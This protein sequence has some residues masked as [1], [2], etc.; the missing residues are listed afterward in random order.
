MI[1]C[2]LQNTPPSLRNPKSPVVIKCGRYAKYFM[3]S[4]TQC[5]FLLIF[6]PNCKLRCRI[7]NYL[8][9]I[10]LYRD[11][12][13]GNSVTL[14]ISHGECDKGWSKNEEKKLQLPEWSFC[15]GK[16]KKD[17]LT[18]ATINLGNQICIFSNYAT[19]CLNISCSM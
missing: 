8:G 6:P 9:V 18:I 17:E 3:N 16:P 7:V 19:F 11:I 2:C 15:L 13:R 10:Y 5:F 12:S 4:Y 14:F 1:D